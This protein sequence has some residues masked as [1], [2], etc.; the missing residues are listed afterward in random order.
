MLNT[1]RY[2]LQKD[3]SPL[4]ALFIQWNAS[5]IFHMCQFNFFMMSEIIVLA[6]GKECA[7]CC[8]WWLHNHLSKKWTSSEVLGFFI[9]SII[10]ERNF[11]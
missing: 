5:S 6:S 2:H 10:E 9:L 4:F 1:S 8:K 11:P 7:F 3:P